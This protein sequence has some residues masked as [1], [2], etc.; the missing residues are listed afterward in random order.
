MKR[1]LLF[2][3]LFVIQWFY[4]QCLVAGNYTGMLATGLCNSLSCNS[5]L[6]SG[7]WMKAQLNEAGIHKITFNDLKMMGFQSPQNVKVFGFPAGMLPQMNQATSP[8]DLIQYA[9]WQ[10]K[11]NKANDCWWI[12]I[13][14]QTIWEADMSSGLYTPVVNQFS[15]GHSCIYLTEDTGISN[16]VKELE[17][18][19]EKA[20]ILVNEFDDFALFKEANYNLIQSGSEWY[21]ALLTPNGILNRTFKFPSHI[22]DEPFR[23]AVAAAGRSELSSA[24]EILINNSAAGTL[25]FSPYSN[26]AEADYANLNKLLVSQKI[27]GTDLKF[28]L[29]YNGTNNSLCWIDY[30]RVQTRSKLSFQSG[31]MI[32][33]DIRS[34]GS[35][36]IAEFRIANAASG[37]TVWDITYPMKPFK[38]HTVISN[39][40]CSFKGLSDSLHRYVAF[41]PLFDFPGI[42]KIEALINQDL[43]GLPVPELL[44]IT[45]PEFRIEADRLADFHRKDNGMEVAEADVN[46][47]YNEFSG[48]IKD[49]TAIRNFVRH[50]YKK[51][52]TGKGSKLKYLLLLGKGTYDNLNPVSIQNP[53]FIPTWQSKNSNNPVA[54]FVSD[55]YFGLL[56][57]DEG[58]QTGI[59]DLGIGRIPC[60]TVKQAKAAVDKI[61]HYNS[62]STLGEWRNIVCFVGDDQDNNIH[63]SDS[64][65]LADYVNI[66]YPAFYTDKIYLDAFVKKMTPAMSYPEVNKAINNRIKEGALI[67]NY[68]GHAN[69]EEW[70]AEKVLTISDVDSWSNFDKLPVFVTA[71]CEFSRWDMTGKE[72]AG[73]HVLFNQAGGGVA[74]FSTTRMVYSSSNFEM[75][76]SF[77]K[78]VFQNDGDG[79]NLRMGDIMR[80]AKGELGGTINGSKF[81][82]LGDPALPLSYPKYKVKTLEINSQVAEQMTDTICPLDLVSVW[83]EIQDVKGVKI[84]GYNGILFPNVYDKPAELTTLGNNG[85]TPFT[86]SL[87]NSVL[88]KGNV[89][90]KQG[91]FSYAFEIPKEINY[92]IGDGM[93]RNYSKDLNR[94]ANGSVTNFKLGGSPKKILNDVTGPTVKLFLDNENFKTGDKVSKAPLLFVNLE[95]ASGINTSGG[96]IGHDISL[97]IDNNAADIIYLNDYFQSELDSYKRGRVL[98]QLPSLSNGE[99]TLKFKVWDLAN[100]STEVEVRFDVATALAIKKVTNFPNPF[101]EYTD[102]IVA[103]N[104]YDEKV[105]IAIEIFN[106]QGSKVD[107]IKTDSGSA[108]FTTIPVRWSPG[109]NSHRLA[110]GIYYYRISLTAVDGSTDSETGQ[111]I[112]NH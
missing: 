91:E 86:Y 20:S 85:Q 104:R 26:F 18:R 28:Q 107:Q 77:F 71:T 110:S 61:I 8:D 57:D 17:P 82:L 13:P 47:I 88:F 54:S 2:L 32:F 38:I 84:S 50:L 46:Q 93:I 109:S 67:V 87:Q 105:T 42:G 11:D 33:C 34:V 103:Y 3:S 100:N 10:F 63:V 89:S 74:L 52:I 19:Q 112:Y 55:D 60:A 70:A 92:R 90:V 96:G 58:G 53:C 64:E 97:I 66:N 108:G 106:Q 5:V 14:E 36:N 101:S 48:G 29:K 25:N 21:S 102:F 49:V 59:V 94:D 30:L 1:R 75:N 7:K 37:L 99:H 6:A 51:G 69:E 78:H 72:S 65:Q 111:I 83:G 22:D 95:D 98:Y 27:S 81:A 24:L 45:A 23:I 68:V 15:L 73:E 56:G 43:H 76:K 9:A 41:D 62:E 40:L 35:G 4:P 39:G 16:L 79:N 12:Y 31:Q 44:I 80:L